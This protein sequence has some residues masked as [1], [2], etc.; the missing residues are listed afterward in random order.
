MESGGGGVVFEN[1]KREMWSI[2]QNVA[3][4]AFAVSHAKDVNV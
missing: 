1:W 2:L 4:Q 3:D